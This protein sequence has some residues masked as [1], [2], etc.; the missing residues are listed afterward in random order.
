MGKGPEAALQR[1]DET[2]LLSF[3]RVRQAHLRF[4]SVL[5][6]SVLQAAQAAAGT[7][8]RSRSLRGTRQDLRMQVRR[9]EEDPADRQA[10][11]WQSR[12]AGLQPDGQDVS[13]PSPC[14]HVLGSLRQGTAT[15]I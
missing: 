4:A 11:C 3:R 9:L 2:A 13:Q 12:S 6:W 10:A 7:A 8:Q 5:L 1:R 15:A 14:N